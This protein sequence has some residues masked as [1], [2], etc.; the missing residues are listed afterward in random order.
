MLSKIYQWLLPFTCVLCGANSKISQDLCDDCKNDLPWI[1]KSCLHCA[2]PLESIV[3]ECGECLKN[4][5]TYDNT[6]ALFFYASPIDKL[7]LRLKFHHQLLYARVLGELF[8]EK[9]IKIYYEKSLPEIIIPVPLHR[10]RLRQRGFNQSLEIAKP[11]SKKLKI[12]IDIKHCQ[13]IRAT[14]AQSLIPATQRYQNVKSA[15]AIAKNFSVKYVAIIDDVMTTGNTVNELS[16]QLRKNG[17]EKIDVWC[18]ARSN[19]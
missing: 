16:K 2:Q 9:L 4:P 13:R 15:F 17:V 19:F 8:A 11:I 5:P 7:I 6:H 18:C 10:S 14:E 12:P 1:K 3:T